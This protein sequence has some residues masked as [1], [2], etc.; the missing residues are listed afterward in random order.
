MKSLEQRSLATLSI[1]SKFS[2]PDYLCPQCCPGTSPVTC[3]LRQRQRAPCVSPR[4][5]CVCPG[6]EIPHASLS[7][8]APGD[9][10]RVPMPGSD[11]SPPPPCGHPGWQQRPCVFLCVVSF[12][13]VSQKAPVTGHVMPYSPAKEL[14][15][16]VSGKPSKDGRAA[17]VVRERPELRGLEATL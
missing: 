13:S 11:E 12:H 3:H 15:Q 6:T 7:C 1:F 17:V 14:W 8:P 4:R 9:C 2:H 16:R 5:G 10:T